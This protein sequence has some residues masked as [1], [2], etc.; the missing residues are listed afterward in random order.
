[1]SPLQT[2]K[3]SQSRPV[4]SAQS[5]RKN[6]GTFEAVKGIDFEIHGGL[7]RAGCGDDLRMSRVCSLRDR[8]RANS[9]A[10]STSAGTARLPR[11]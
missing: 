1:M 11:L 8:K 3:L 4:I 7:R 9:A 6:F 2:S 5:L 10:V